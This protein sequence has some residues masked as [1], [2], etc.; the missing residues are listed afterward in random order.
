MEPKAGISLCISG[1][2]TRIVG[3]RMCQIEKGTA[4]VLSPAVPT[5]EVE[6]SDDFEECTIMERLSLIS[7][8]MSPFFSR[9]VPTVGK[10]VLCVRLDEAAAAHFISTAQRIAAREALSPD[11][12]VLKELNDH[13]TSL[14]RVEKIIEVL[15]E[16]ASRR[17]PTIEK[18]SRGEQVFVGFVQSLALHYAD[19]REV[20]DYAAEACLSV[21]HFSSLI[22]KHTGHTPMYWIHIIIIISRA[23]HLLM[24]QDLRVKDI[25]DRLGFPEQFTF[26]KYFKTHTGMS[27]TEYRRLNSSH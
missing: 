1:T 18:P 13:I 17:N 2:A 11:A 27:P 14:M 22:Q 21:R 7:G 6:R 26:R 3:S 25:A 5:M 10:E 20:G 23:K 19:R 24:Q 16:V 12:E 9:L 15:Y 4:M 8:Q